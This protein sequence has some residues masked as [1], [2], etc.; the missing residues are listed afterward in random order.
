[1]VLKGIQKCFK[2]V[3]GGFWEE[4]QDVSGDLKMLLESSKYA[5]RG[6]KVLVDAT[7][8]TF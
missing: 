7:P 8:H 2:R 6:S 1:M 4:F 3:S 5:Y